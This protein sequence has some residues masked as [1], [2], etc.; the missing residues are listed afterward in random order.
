MEVPVIKPTVRIIP[1]FCMSVNKSI[2]ILLLKWNL[3]KKMIREKRG[4]GFIN[5][6]GLI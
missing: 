4:Y 6:H 2:I 5:L 1:F 3:S